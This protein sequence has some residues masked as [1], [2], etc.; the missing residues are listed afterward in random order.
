VKEKGIIKE[1]K[2]DDDDYYYKT[3]FEYN[4]RYNI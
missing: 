3:K 4:Y 1:E 2:E